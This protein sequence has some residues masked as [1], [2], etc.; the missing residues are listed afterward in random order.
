MPWKRTWK[1]IMSIERI[2]PTSRVA[3]LIENEP[4]KHPDGGGLYLQVAS[5]G[6]ASWVFRHKEKWGSIGPANA[7]KI[8]EAREKARTLRKE[9]AE[10]RDP[11]VL[12]RSQRQPLAVATG[13]S[14]ATAL[15]EYLAVK[16]PTWA[17]S[18]RAKELRVYERLFDQIPQFT[19]LPVKGISQDAIND[20]LA[21]WNDQPKR[22]RDV[23]F[24]IGAVIKHA[25]EGKLRITGAKPE[26]DHHEAM[27]YAD[28]PA[29]YAG[30]PDTV[31]GR[32]L[33][34]TILTGARTDEV[35]GAKKAG[36]WTKA[37]ATW[38]EIVGDTWVVPAERMKGKRTHHVP[39][40]P[41]M[42]ALLGERCADDVPL[43]KV[44]SVNNALLNTLK[45]NGGNGYTVHG[46]R[47]SFSDWVLD[48]TNYGG[49]LADLCIAHLTTNKVRAAYQR[50]PQLDKRRAIF[51][52]WN[53][54]VSPRVDVA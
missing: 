54:Y 45:A 26:Q 50:S 32:A 8:E 52:E 51:R 7:Y 2:K 4:G 40:S 6:N 46:M 33:R 16:A 37:P 27:P 14:F 20:A 12:L 5:P 35:V 18:N 47:S 9:V 23:G 21:H 15:A 48:K 41:Q 28:V 43:F 36:E 44:G 39:L 31:E 11:F 13:K 53:D 49:D 10:G 22:R 25:V 1:Q 3:H 19:A 34:W 17:A 42:V 30:L 29:C 24:Y 38:S